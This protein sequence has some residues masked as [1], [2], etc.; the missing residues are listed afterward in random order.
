MG[1]VGHGGHVEVSRRSQPSILCQS[2]ELVADPLEGAQNL[3][4][5]SIRGPSSETQGGH[6]FLDPSGLLF[7]PSPPPCSQVALLPVHVPGTVPLLISRAW[8]ILGYSAP[9]L[10]VNCTPSLPLFNGQ[11]LYV[12]S[13]QA[14]VGNSLPPSA[15]GASGSCHALVTPTALSHQAHAI[16]GHT[17]LPLPSPPP[18]LCSTP[19]SNQRSGMPTG[20]SWIQNPPFVLQTERRQGAGAGRAGDPRPWSDHLLRG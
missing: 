19:N 9:Q 14:K 6:F 11:D 2:K 8:G 1:S 5:K 7:L 12:L 10:L 18:H 20:W 4:G 3:A 16:R 13:T 17:F 15:T